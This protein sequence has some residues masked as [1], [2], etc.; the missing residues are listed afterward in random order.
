MHMV[1]IAPRLVVLG[2]LT[3]GIQTPAS[4]EHRQ[5]AST[6]AEVTIP[7]NPPTDAVLTYRYSATDPREEH[8]GPH[9]FD[10][11][12]TFARAGEYYVMTVVAPVP[13]GLPDEM[14]ALIQ[15][16]FSVRLGPDG[17]MIGIVDEAR[18]WA[19]VDQVT[20]TIT[21][22]NVR[23]ATATL[24]ARMRALPPDELLPMISRSFAPIIA[25]AGAELP[26]GEMSPPD[27]ERESVAGRMTMHSRVLVEVLDADRAQITIVGTIPPEQL[28]GAMSGLFRDL[29]PPGATSFTG[30]EDRQ[31]SIVSR[32][33]GLAE[34]WVS[35]R[36]VTIEWNGAPQTVVQTRELHWVH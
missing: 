9:S 19:G 14:A 12:V 2:L 29:A 27:E 34:S 36:T 25:S 22:A 7:F 13:P 3:A 26:I 10:M 28:S 31:T 24:V 11:N 4:A 20:Q 33:T 6:P 30:F 21:D 8:P 1:R 16:P 18:F 35:A 32:R 15:R 5:R 23:Q 17:E